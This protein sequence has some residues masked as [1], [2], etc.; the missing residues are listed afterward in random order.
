MKTYVSY[1]TH[2]VR[3]LINMLKIFGTKAVQRSQTHISFQVRFTRQFYGFRD[4][5]QKGSL[6]CAILKVSGLILEVLALRAHALEFLCNA[7]V[8]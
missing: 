6:Y 2:F 1:W 7:C 8:S 5:V 3:N 4:N